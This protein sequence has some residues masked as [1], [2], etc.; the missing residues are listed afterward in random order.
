[1]SDDGGW[2]DLSQN[3]YAGQGSD[4]P[5]DGVL[6]SDPVLAI[7][8]GQAGRAAWAV[9]GYAGTP[10]AAGIGSGTI[11]PARST[12]WRTSSSAGFST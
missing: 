6:K 4:L 7:A 3:Q 8:A 9:G 11:L 10:T 5:G 1:M 12:G 2:Q